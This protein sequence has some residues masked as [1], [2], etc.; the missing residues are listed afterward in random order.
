MNV[1]RVRVEQNDPR[2]RLGELRNSDLDEFVSDLDEFAQTDQ[3]ANSSDL[4]EF[5]PTWINLLKT[6]INLLRTWMNLL[7]PG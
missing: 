5:A 3:C 6:W 1:F 4:D 2:L 7:R